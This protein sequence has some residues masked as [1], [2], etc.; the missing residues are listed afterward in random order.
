[1]RLD[2]FCRFGVLLRTQLIQA[3]YEQKHVEGLRIIMTKTLLTACKAIVIDGQ[4][5]G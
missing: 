3:H 1:M 2:I 5:L 4:Y